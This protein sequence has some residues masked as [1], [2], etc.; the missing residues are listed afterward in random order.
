MNLPSCK[1]RPNNLSVENVHEL[2]AGED[3]CVD[4]F[5][6]C[7]VAFPTVDDDIPIQFVDQSLHKRNTVPAMQASWW[8]SDLFANCTAY[9][10]TA[11]AAPYI[12]S[13][14]CSFAGVNAV[15]GQGARKAQQQLSSPPSGTA[16]ASSKDVLGM[17]EHDMRRALSALG[18]V[19]AWCPHDMELV[20][21]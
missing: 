17:W 9:A 15:A 1:P 5:D 4:T 12:T 10:L 20:D 21:I 7:L 3:G 16:A 19:A 8:I 13:G 18:E 11:D 6:D 2:F 14:I